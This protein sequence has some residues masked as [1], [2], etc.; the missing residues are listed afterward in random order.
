MGAVRSLTK[1]REIELVARASSLDKREGALNK[2]EEALNNLAD[3]FAK[4]ELALCRPPE[5]S[6]IMLHDQPNFNGFL[7]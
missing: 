1:E 2:R 3:E 7:G 6:V 5:Q 4:R